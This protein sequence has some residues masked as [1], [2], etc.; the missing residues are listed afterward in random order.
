MMSSEDEK[1]VRLWA[2]KLKNGEVPPWKVED[3]MSALHHIESP[4]QFKLA[5]L[6]R[7]CYVEGETGESFHFISL[8][9]KPYKCVYRCEKD[10]LEYELDARDTSTEC[11][12]CRGKL[13]PLGRYAPLVA[14]Y[15]GGVEAYYS[16][17]GRIKVRGTSEKTFTNLLVYGTGQGPIGVTR[18]CHL[19]NRFGGAQVTVA[20][21]G[22]AVRSLGF[23]FD[24]PQIRQQAIRAIEADWPNLQRQMEDRLGEFLGEVVSIG[25]DCAESSRGYLLF[26][27]FV[28]EF[29]NFRGH[30]D[31]SRV[32]GWAKDAIETLLSSHG[33][34]SKID[35]VAQG[36]DGDLKPS[37]K[38]KR[39]RHSLAEVHVP[40]KDFEESF[41]LEVDRFLTSVEIDNIGAQKLGCQ[42]YSGMGGEIIP[43]VYKA[44]NVNPQSSLVTS[45]ENITAEV[46]DGHLIFRVELPNVEVGVASNR[47]GLIPPS[48]RE[49]L[50]V[51][52]VRSAK[53]FAASLAAQVLAGE[54]NL[55]LEIARGRLYKS[56]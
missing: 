9:E 30:G 21:S 8:P 34:A 29:E 4:N 54:F 24:S 10:D 13:N 26:V 48:G 14:N 18:G 35:I 19:I 38:N 53:D 49:A 51:M 55:A 2:D 36:H 56:Q 32:V 23:L 17:A 15:I 22:R 52:G 5:V 7:Q 11:L 20:D 25:F 50:R 27:E 43:A 41:G 16:F 37:P 12:F 28:T 45:F 3:E 6:A 44:T 1:I 47:E 33:V 39:G 42:F 46:K 40:Q 31:T